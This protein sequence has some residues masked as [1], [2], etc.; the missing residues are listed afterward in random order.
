MFVAGVM[1]ALGLLRPLVTKLADEPID[2]DEAFELVDLGI[3]LE[4]LATVIKLIATDSVGSERWRAAGFRSAAAWMAAKTGTPVGPAV[5]AMD[6]LGLIRDLPATA[7]AL[8]T[9]RLSLLQV[10][11]VAAVASEW[12]E[13]EQELL[14]AADTLSLNELRDTCRRVQAAMVIDEED[15]HRRIRKGRYLRSW[16]DRSGAVRLSARLT[17]EEGARL[18]AEVDARCDAIV[19]D[20]KAG[21]WYES[22]EAHRADALVDLARSAGADES[23]SAPEALIHVWVDYDALMR[24]HTVAG[25]QCEIPGVGPIP[26]S[27]ARQ[28]ANDAYLKVL[29]T[30]GEDI[31]VVAHAGRTIPAR[32]RTAVEC[33]DPECIVP[34]CEE[35]RRLQIDH[36]QPVAAQ[37]LTRL[38]NLARL[39][40]RHHYEKSVLGYRYR[41]GPG[42]W[43]W[44]APDV[45]PPP[46][47]TQSSGVAW[48]A[49][50]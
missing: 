50:C 44:V 6:T 33:R 32:L 24:G 31:T 48:R 18:L 14:D 38:D 22:V 4:R 49:R 41:G 30:K 1:D 40:R 12:P 10:S 16:T 36:R 45:A 9:G 37:G 5:A 7:D 47:E 21:G 34:G 23:S 19:D 27:V 26:V 11:E 3:E 46:R 13:T 39:C 25:E 2:S 15:R 8:L 29:V 35:R 43:E 28:L 20:A 17:P 42:T